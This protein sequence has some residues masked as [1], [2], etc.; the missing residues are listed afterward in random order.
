MIRMFQV[1]MAAHAPQ[2]VAAVLE[3]GYIGQGPKVEQLESQLQA[4]LGHRNLLA[5]NSCTA[6]L[7]LSLHLIGVGPGDEVV[8]TP[9]T[10]TATN[11]VIVRR[12]A[13]P[14]WADVD[15]HTGLI[16][17]DDVGRKITPRTKAIMAVD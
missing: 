6:A 11:A 16:S 17:P 14:V 13:T 15:P 9:I 8:T 10:C 1:R 3:S 5:L 2:M 4:R 12:G 7:D